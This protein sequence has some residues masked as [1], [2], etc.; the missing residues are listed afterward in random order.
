[1]SFT[2]A[3]KVRLKRAVKFL[4]GDCRDEAEPQA[5]LPGNKGVSPE[6]LAGAALASLLALN[7]LKPEE[8]RGMMIFF[9]SIVPE[10]IP[11]YPPKSP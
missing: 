3:Q 7:G 11:E 6:I 5:L 4:V 1:M 2:E 9:A 10:Q 8:M